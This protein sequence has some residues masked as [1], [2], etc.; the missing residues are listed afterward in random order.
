[1]AKSNAAKGC[2]FVGILLLLAAAS[3]LIW[4]FVDGQD[5]G[6]QSNKNINSEG[7]TL[8]SAFEDAKN[9]EASE[10]TDASDPVV[11]TTAAPTAMPTSV[12]YPF[13]QCKEDPSNNN[14]SVTCCNG[15]NNICVFPVN[16]ILFGALHNAMATAADNFLLPNHNR[17]VRE[18]LEAGFRGINV[19]VCNCLGEYQLCHGVCG[20]GQVNPVA[21]IGDI[22]SFLDENPNEVVLLTME[23]NSNA[24]EEVDLDEFNT[25]VLSQVEGFHDFLY[26]REN[27][28]D[29]WPT[30]RE[31]IEQDEVCIQMHDFP[32][33]VAA[34]FGVFV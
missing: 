24:G 3:I 14:S 8:D 34:L 2:I 1:M 26:S 12:P 18:A 23:L 28:N 20:L 27:R 29:P 32:F 13:Y 4:W 31:L 7:N 16:E 22:T 10:K 6:S 25:T 33:S 30:L 15:L 11:I 21:L 19:D 9:E 17:P 5:D